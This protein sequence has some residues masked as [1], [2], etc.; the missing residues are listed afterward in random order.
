LKRLD[1]KTDLTA[2]IHGENFHANRIALLEEIMHVVHI[3]IG[4]LRDVNEPCLSF[5][6]FDESAK[7]RDPCND[8]F[9]YTANFNGQNTSSLQYKTGGVTPDD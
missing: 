8:A 3:D 7:I 4:N 9:Y 1:G 6:E 2:V 5:R